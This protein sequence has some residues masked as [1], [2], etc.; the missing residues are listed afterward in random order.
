MRLLDPAGWPELGIEAPNSTAILWNQP[1]E[2]EA[3]QMIEI[4][5]ISVVRNV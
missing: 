3:L 5:G 2:E 1:R 4:G